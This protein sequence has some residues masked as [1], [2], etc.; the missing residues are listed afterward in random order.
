[1]RTPVE[2]PRKGELVANEK[3]LNPPWKPGQTGNPGGRPKL[4]DEIKSIRKLSTKS[5]CELA[6][7]LVCG[8]WDELE[9]L[10]KSPNE[11]AIKVKIAKSILSEDYRTLDAILNRLIGKPADQ[12]N[13][14][15]AVPTIIRMRS[16]ETEVLGQKLI[17]ADEESEDE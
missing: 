16:G 2:T 13:V 1:M 6:N 17:D 14:Q 5:F 8:T 3:N 9:K 15:M 11:S 4:P 7:I 12:V 10:A